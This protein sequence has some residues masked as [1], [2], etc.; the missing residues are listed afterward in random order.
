MT[1]FVRGIALLMRHVRLGNKLQKL[2]NHCLNTSLLKLFKPWKEQV[3]MEEACH[4]LPAKDLMVLFH[5][6][7]VVNNRTVYGYHEAFESCSDERNKS[8]TFILP[9]LLTQVSLLK[10]FRTWRSDAVS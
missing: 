6:G 10:V 8:S 3:Q 2:G 7:R 4:S 5:V 1:T 9:H